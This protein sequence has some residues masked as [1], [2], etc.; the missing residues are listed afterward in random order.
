MFAC[1]SQLGELADLVQQA[2]QPLAAA[3]DTLGRTEDAQIRVLKAQLEQMRFYDQRLLSTVYWA[4]GFIGGLTAAL[5]GLGWFANFRLHSRELGALRQELR[6]YLQEEFAKLQ[7]G[8]QS[9]AIQRHDALSKRVRD[10]GEV[11]AKQVHAELASRIDTLDHELMEQRYDV[12]SLR[13]DDWEARGVHINA[14]RWY[15]KLVELGRAMEQD[16]R[17]GNAL[18]KIGETLSTIARDNASRPDTNMTRE[19]LELLESIPQ[20]FSVDKEAIRTTLASLRGS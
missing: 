12:L 18:A 5:V 8:M 14:L 19:I 9:E 15:I 7:Q 13:A 11:A 6:G 16:W 4:L 17:V 3:I 1:I 2:A 20:S 10:A